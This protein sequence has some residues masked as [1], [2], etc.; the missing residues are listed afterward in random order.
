[1]Y[2]KSPLTPDVCV[3]T[4]ESL[5]TSLASLSPSDHSDSPRSE[6]QTLERISTLTGVRRQPGAQMHAAVSVCLFVSF[7]I[8][9][10]P[11]PVTEQDVTVLITCCGFQSVLNNLRNTGGRASDILIDLLCK[12]AATVSAVCCCWICCVVRLSLTIQSVP[13]QLSRKRALF[14]KFRSRVWHGKTGL[15]FDAVQLY[16][17]FC[18]RAFISFFPRH[19]CLV[20]SFSTNQRIQLGRKRWNQYPSLG[21]KLMVYSRE[22]SLFA[23]ES[24]GNMLG[25]AVGWC[26]IRAH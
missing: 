5:N 11:K 1:M 16:A 7:D 2:L 10:E 14:L 20:L 26:I 18:L 19:V 9:S 4:C 17:Y 12:V 13:P 15:W 8:L 25:W 6:P 22:Q 21:R 24:S 3:D 23:V